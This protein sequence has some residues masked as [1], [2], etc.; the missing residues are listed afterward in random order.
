MPSKPTRRAAAPAAGGGAGAGGGGGAG[1]GR[2]PAAN[3]KSRR[4]GTDR[5]DGQARA[6][7]TP[8]RMGYRSRFVPT[9]L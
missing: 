4:C 5:T 3:A 9:L 6:F 2:S 1:A 7:A 8:V